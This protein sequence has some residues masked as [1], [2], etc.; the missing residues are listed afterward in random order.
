MK[1]F[2]LLSALAVLLACKD[3]QPVV[4]QPVQPAVQ[5]PAWVASRPVSDGYYIGIGLAA[6]RG[7]Q[8]HQE[9]AKKNALNDLASE[10]SVKVEGNSLL[11]T[12]DR[13][14]SFDESFTSTINTRTSEQLEGYELVDTWENGTEYWTYY[15]LSK[16]EHARIKAERKRQAVQQA[17]DLYARA[18]QSLATG[19]L[20]SAFDKDLR[21]LLAM[22][23][24]WGEN[25]TA[26]VNGRNVSLA[27][28]LYNDLQRLMAG[29]RITALPE[30]CV[31][32][33]GNHFSREMLLRAQFVQGTAAR[34]LAQLPLVLSYP[35]IAGPVTELRGTDA[36]GQVRTTVQ[37]VDLAVAGPALLARLDMEALVPKDVDQAFAKPL[38]ASLNAPELRVPID[39]KL[40]KVHMTV[41]ERNMGEPL[42][43]G[44]A[45]LT[46]KQELTTRGFR[47]VDR[48]Q[49]A[50]L[51]MTV[52]ASTREG[53]EGNGF[54][55]AFLDLAIACRDRRTQ[56]VVYT[57]GKQGI[58]GV[59]L[60]Y[61]K[62]G[63]EAYKKAGQ[64][65]RQ[66]VVPALLNAIL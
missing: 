15:R 38:V 9:T 44:G 12:L 30:R 45:A 11:Y 28:E 34:D 23:A 48:E 63:M 31:L 2:L 47:F 14:T 49:D 18:Q 58:K 60:N 29:T 50:D 39:V 43:E 27:N 51:L 64:D 13:K 33:H 62:A 42:T 53:G 8:D 26:T 40:P 1:R 16:A 52:T 4:Q 7:G 25:D 32:E 66:E 19:D 37:K 24:Y 54:H 21:A 41:M 22:K 6:V 46:I 20:R 35:G 5:R 17:S 55:T 36:E 57:G 65:I 59:Q 56:D 3:K 10:I 61:P